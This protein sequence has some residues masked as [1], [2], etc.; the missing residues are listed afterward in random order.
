M[1][2]M[3]DVIIKNLNGVKHEAPEFYGGS[4]LAVLKSSY[5]VEGDNQFDCYH[6]AMPKVE[7]QSFFTD[8]K[9]IDLPKNT[10]LATNPGQNLRV[11]PINVKYHN[12][13]D[14]K[15]VCMF[16]ETHKLQEL[17]KAEYNK[18][19]LLFKNNISYLNNNILA[20]ISQLEAESRNKQLGY[21][22]ILDC[23]S[24]EISVNMLR[25]LKS[26]MPGMRELRKYTAK[27]EINTVIDYLWEDVNKE[28][29]LDKLSRIANLSPYYLVRLFKDNTGKTPYAYY[30]DIKISKAIEYLRAGKHS[31]TEVSFILGFSSHSHFSSIFKKKV[32]MTPSDFI[33]SV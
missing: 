31:M 16:I 3:G 20:L 23:L 28:F 19:D 33:K 13:N 27:N 21:R 15:F 11:S 7:V 12:S 6:F 22:F 18:T 9:E 26:N 29:S 17:S 2:L 4:D 25:E 5:F 14:I 24:I 32:G 1:E 8:N 10:I 30:M